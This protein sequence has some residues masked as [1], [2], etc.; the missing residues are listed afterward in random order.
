[1]A[2]RTGTLAVGGAVAEAGVGAVVGDAVAVAAGGE[3][4]AGVVVV[5]V[6]GDGER[7]EAAGRRLAQSDKKGRRLFAATFRSEPQSSLSKFSGAPSSANMALYPDMRTATAS[8]A[9]SMP[10][11][12]KL[13]L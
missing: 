6:A 12:C 7:R 13:L 11:V 3:G 9:Q 8:I 5:V 2:S 1:M 10:S 4:V